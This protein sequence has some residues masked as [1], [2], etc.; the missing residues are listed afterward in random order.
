MSR[1]QLPFAIV[2]S[3][4]AL[5][6]AA[7]PLGA[8]SYAAGGGGGGQLPPKTPQDSGW[9]DQPTKDPQGPKGPKG[10]KND[11]KDPDQGPKDELDGAYNGEVVHTSEDTSNKPTAQPLTAYQMPFPCGEV[12]TGSTRASHSPSTRSVDFNRPDD[13]QDPVVAAADGVVT[14]AVT[15]KK[16]PSYGQFVVIDHGNDE[17]TLYAHLDSVTVVVGQAVT[18]GTQVGTL[19][20][21]GNSYGAH[22]HFEERKGTSVVDSWFDG[23]AYD[24]DTAQASNNCGKVSVPDVPLAG[25]VL[26]DKR[27]ELAVYRTTG[28]PAFYVRREP[29]ADKVI[30]FGQPTDKPLLG[31]WDGN[32]KANPGVRR[33]KVFLLKNKRNVV[34]VKFGGKAD[35]GLVGDWDGDGRWEVGTRRATSNL[36][37]LRAAD[38]TLT[39]VRLGDADDLPV[40]GDWDGDGVTDLG[41][42]DSA[43]ATFTLRRVDDTGMEWL[44]QVGL[45]AAG[46]L[47]V[48]GDWDA[49]GFTDLGVWNPDTATF[50]K[51]ESPT[52]TTQG[53]KHQKVHRVR[54]GNGR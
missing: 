54:Y 53:K 29:K 2:A 12:W 3:T 40:T 27:A 32:G 33:G 6:V 38:G 8:V 42:Y 45:G 35:I 24:Y 9:G 36:F 47:P 19:G 5:A 37:R 28:T 1:R 51:L 14:T 48:T 50:T 39:K 7:G 44:S 22:L 52:P 34:E 43:T 13:F 23:V 49:N 41:V 17:S 21:T 18:S 15:G 31:D 30:K 25:N 4:V 16:R 11:P 20:N 46:D 10:G 26:G